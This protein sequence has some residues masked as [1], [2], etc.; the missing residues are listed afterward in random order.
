MRNVFLILIRRIA[1]TTLYVIIILYIWALDISTLDKHCS[2]FAAYS[3]RVGGWHIRILGGC[4]L[5]YKGARTGSIRMNIMA[6]LAWRL[7]SKDHHSVA[8]NFKLLSNVH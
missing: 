6:L 3:L 5:V 2:L 7:A 4:K 8:A 1:F